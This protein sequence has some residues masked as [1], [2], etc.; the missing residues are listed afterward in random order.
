MVQLYGKKRYFL[1][2]MLINKIQYEKIINDN[3]D[4]FVFTCD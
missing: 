2:K 3:N 4:K 1:L